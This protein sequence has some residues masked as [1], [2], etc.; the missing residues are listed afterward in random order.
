M[1]ETMATLNQEL[2]VMLKGSPSG[3]DGKGYDNNDYQQGLW[4]I[5]PIDSFP[6][7][8]GNCRSDWVQCNPYLPSSNPK[9]GL[10]M[11]VEIHTKTI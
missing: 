6:D 5:L 4:K 11:E 3:G 8:Y 7:K 9:Y 1:T 10:S 2:K